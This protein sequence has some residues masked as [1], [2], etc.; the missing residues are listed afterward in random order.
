MKRFAKRPVVIV[1][2]TSSVSCGGKLDVPK[3]AIADAQPTGIVKRELTVA[4]PEVTFQIRHPWNRGNTV[5]VRLNIDGL[6]AYG[7]TKEDVMR[8]LTPSGIVDNKEPLP[9]PGVVFDSQLHNPDWYENMILKA[10]AEGDI[11]RLKDVAKLEWLAG[12]E[13]QEVEP[14]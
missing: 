9:P 2:L 11:V 8:A 10:N 14:K 1:L 6:R 5:K 3:G 4:R 7:L 13:T 12:R